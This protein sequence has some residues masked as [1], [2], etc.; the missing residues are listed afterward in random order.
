M[1]YSTRTHINANKQTPVEPS[2]PDLQDRPFG[3]Q[4][5]RP[6]GSASDP[7]NQSGGSSLDSGRL[8]VFPNAPASAIQAEAQNTANAP[9]QLAR[10]DD[11]LIE[12]QRNRYEALMGRRR[13]PPEA[14]PLPSNDHSP[15]V[16]P[17]APTPEAASRPLVSHLVPQPPPG[18]HDQRGRQQNTS[19]PSHAVPAMPA[20]HEF[21]GGTTRSYRTVPPGPNIAPFPL[22]KNLPLAMRNDAEARLLKTQTREQR[23]FSGNEKSERRDVQREQVSQWDDIQNQI[24]QARLPRR[25]RPRGRT[26]KTGAWPF[27][28]W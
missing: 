26:P 14:H 9:I 23:K 24:Q 17:E 2:K 21:A 8:T 19:R 3:V 12:E 22:Q 6:V 15:S 16:R 1:V 18:R 27:G 7:Q 10:D 5:S 13:L 20:P 4:A 25:P 11:K 28:P